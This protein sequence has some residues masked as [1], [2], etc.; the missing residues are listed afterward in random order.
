VK[1]IIKPKGQLQYFKS[2]VDHKLYPY[3]ICLTDTS[4]DPVEKPLIVEVSP[5]GWGNLPAAISRTETMATM[6]MEAG[7]S[8]IVLRPTGRGNGSL[9]QNYG[10]V[11]V[12]EAID[13]VIQNHAIDQNRVTITGAS[14]GGAATWYLITHYP[15]LFAAAAPFCGYCDYQLWEKPGG[16]TF[17]MHPWEEPSWQSRS[18]VRIIENLQHTPIWIVHGE[19]DRAVGGGVPVAHSRQMAEK[20]ASL[21]YPY[22]YTEVPG[23]GHGCQ[24]GEIWKQTIIWLLQQRKERHPKQVSLATYS[25]RHNRSHWVR[26]DQLEIYGQRS[27]V[28]AELKD[29]LLRVQTRNVQTLSLGPI[30]NHGPAALMIDD[31]QVGTVNSGVEKQFQRGVTGEWTEDGFDLSGQ[32]KP[33]NAGPI[34]DL[35][36]EQ[37][38]LVPGT[39]GSA[40]ETFFNNWM[41]DNTASYFRSWNGGVHRGGI[42]GDNAIDLTVVPDSDLNEKG[43]LSSHLA[44]A[45]LLLLGTYRSNAVLAQFEGRLPLIFS[46]RGIQLGSQEYSGDNVAVL[47][48][49]P[50]PNHPYRYVAVHGGVRPDATTW[51]SHLHLQL[52]PDY[53]VY[54]EGEVLDWGFWSNQWEIQLP[55]SHH[56]SQ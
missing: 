21:G 40:E 10:E 9:Y 32:K 52:L 36:F 34:G 22:R 18:A 25:L 12:L 1:S 3:A 24:T 42:V 29:N 13:H 31:Q 30:S 41:A 2:K 55:E 56:Y 19:W 53:I 37:L 45:N 16:L 8:C 51:G 44:E 5:G 15:D 28:E 14:M 38:L 27:L 6:A 20:L 35:F 46:A 11:D 43:E 54:C 49:F 39:T 7:M 48:I 33:Q 23:T 17:H 47:A 4:D 26:I 50:H